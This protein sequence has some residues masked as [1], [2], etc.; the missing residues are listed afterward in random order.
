MGLLKVDDFKPGMV[1]AEDLKSPQGRMLLPKGAVLSEKHIWTCKIWGIVEGD[2]LGENGQEGDA[3]PVVLNPALLNQARELAKIFFCLDDVRHPM[4]REAIKLYIER[5]AQLLAKDEAGSCAVFSRTIDAPPVSVWPRKE[6]IENVV[7]QDLELA[8]HPEIF[9]HVLQAANDPQSSAAY[10]AD[11][12][13]KDVALSVKLLKV[14]N[15]PYYGFPQKVDT[16]SRAIVLLGHNK[17]INLAMG[18]SVISMFQGL[19]SDMLDMSGFW[20]H[21]VACGVVGMIL[22]VHCGE[23][24]EE[25]FFVAGLLHDLG[26]LIMLKNRLDAVHGVFNEYRG[27]KVALHA[28][29]SKR[30]GFNHAELAQQVMEKWQL[31]EN[32]VLAVGEHHSPGSSGYAREA[33][34]THVAD[35]LAH[36]L[37][38]GKSG[39]TLAPPLDIEA[40]ASLGLSKNVLPVLARQVD[41]Q[42]ADIMRVFFG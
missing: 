1:L 23:Q 5:T 21:S 41:K 8:S 42:V 12:V 36:S 29:E 14:V 7:R 22:A 31:P 6:N 28:L 27:Q 25:R 30:W 39:A 13:S 18:I 26:R 9:R 17:I 38:L 24:D 15:T 16:L 20:K 11:L 19:Q 37:A 32:L 2:V 3:H 10:V 33:A 35:F 40:W 4:V 34:V